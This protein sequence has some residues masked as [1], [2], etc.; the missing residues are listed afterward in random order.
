MRFTKNVCPD[1]GEDFLR[2]VKERTAFVAKLLHT[3]TSEDRYACEVL[4]YWPFLPY[5]GVVCFEG[6]QML[7]VPFRQVVIVDASEECFV[8]W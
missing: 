1:L 6:W 2:K 7:K 8:V 5:R 3:G 4:I